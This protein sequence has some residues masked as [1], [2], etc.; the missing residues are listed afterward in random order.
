MRVKAWLAF[1]ISG[2]LALYVAPI[3]AMAGTTGG[4]TGR[5]VDSGTQVPLAN[6]A[7]TITSPSQTATATSDANGSYRFLSLAPDT[8]TLNFNKDGYTPVSNPGLS[9]F[10]DQIQTVNIAMTP[11]LKTIA[12][13]RS[14]AGTD[15][16]KAGT[17]S[18]VYSV[19]AAGA[20]AAQSLIGPGGLNNAYGAVASVPGVNIDAGEQGWFQTVHIRGGD[21]DQVGYELGHPGQ[22]RLRQRA[23]D[24]A[25]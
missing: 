5:V 7:V 10:A 21:I 19:N 12:N 18:D 14:R 23:A 25:Q 15:I 3:A 9:I 16:V 13:V 6:V 8:Y 20:S 11:T 24:D 4:V 2:V 17:T 22:P 1:C